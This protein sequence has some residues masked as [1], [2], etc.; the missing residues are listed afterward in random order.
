[1]AFETADDQRLSWAGEFANIVS[2]QGTRVA[3]KT[4]VPIG[5]A[6]AVG[7]AQLTYRGGPLLTQVKAFPFHQ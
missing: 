2:P 6:P 1:M 5:V 3:G 4:T 7:A